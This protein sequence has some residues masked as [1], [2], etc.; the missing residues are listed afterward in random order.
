MQAI[1]ASAAACLGIIAHLRGLETASAVVGAKRQGI[2]IDSLT[3]GTAA[4]LEVAG[5]IAILGI[6]ALI[7]R[8]CAFMEGAEKILALRFIEFHGLLLYFSSCSG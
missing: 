4:E 5:A 1:T 8:G 6:A 2:V 7:A 3:P